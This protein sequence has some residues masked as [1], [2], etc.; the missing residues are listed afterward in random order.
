MEISISS[1]NILN[2]NSYLPTVPILTKVK[3]KKESDL[4]YVPIFARNLS[5]V[6]YTIRKFRNV[7]IV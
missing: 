2:N 6:M 4:T 7:P 5:I 3:S 1:K